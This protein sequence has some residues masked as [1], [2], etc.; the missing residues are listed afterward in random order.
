MRVNP[1]IAKVQKVRKAAKL[2]L[3]QRKHPKAAEKLKS[4][5]TK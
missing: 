5:G 2:T 4:Q 1:C 3:N